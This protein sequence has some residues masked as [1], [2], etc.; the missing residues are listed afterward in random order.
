M[1]EPS[2]LVKGVLRRVRGMT[3]R[4]LRDLRDR[5][6]DQLGEGPAPTSVREPRTPMKPTAGAAAKTKQDQ[7][8]GPVKKTTGGPKK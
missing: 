2:D 6:T 1:E 4:E 7:D 3:A 8:P 5:I